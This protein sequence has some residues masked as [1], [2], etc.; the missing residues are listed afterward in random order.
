MTWEYLDELLPTHNGCRDHLLALFQRTT[1]HLIPLYAEGAFLT[2]RDGATA[3]RTSCHL[4][5]PLLDPRDHPRYA[6][7]AQTFGLQR[8]VEHAPFLEADDFRPG[9]QALVLPA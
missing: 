7:T 9:R 1:D 6:L 5:L 2:C 3:V 8:G 4:V